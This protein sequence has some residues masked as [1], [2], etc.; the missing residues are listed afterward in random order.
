MF[1]ILLMR[2]YFHYY[3]LNLN[4][5]WEQT[6]IRNNIMELLALVNIQKSTV[7]VLS[8]YILALSVPTMVIYFFI[9]LAIVLN[10]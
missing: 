7:L 3:E 4:L 2:S 8:A 5:V 10:V 9:G 1:A 6:Q